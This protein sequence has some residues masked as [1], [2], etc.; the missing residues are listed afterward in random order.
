MLTTKTDESGISYRPEA[1]TGM[2]ERS[3]PEIGL[4]VCSLNARDMI[5]LPMSSSNS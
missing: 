1:V 3:S 5:C 4:A 2:R